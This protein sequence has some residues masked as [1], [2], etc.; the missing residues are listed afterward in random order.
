[1][2]ASDQLKQD[3]REGRIDADQLIDIIVS[4][5]RQLTAARQERESA[6]QELTAAKQRIA[7]LEKQAGGPATVKLNEPFSMRAEEKRQEQRHKKKKPKPASKGRRGR[8]TSADKLK[9][10][11]RTEKV[12]PEG[13]PHHDCRLSH[14]RPVW[15]LE[16]GRAVLIAYEIYR[17]PKKQYGQIAGVLGR[18]EF[19]LE[20]VVEIACLRHEQ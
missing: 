16:N 6:R 8:L 7:E 3:L 15:R 10:A 14:T 19:G 13:I 20:I 5:Q 2:D 18:S 11:E 12:F 1:M 4:L 17:G 9:H